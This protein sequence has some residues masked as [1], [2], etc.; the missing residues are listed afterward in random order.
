[1]LFLAGAYPRLTAVM[2]TR[3]LW[4]KFS[5]LL[6]LT[7]PR[8]RKRWASDE[9]LTTVGA[10]WR[11]PAAPSCLTAGSETRRGWV[12][13]NFTEPKRRSSPP[14]WPESLFLSPPKDRRRRSCKS[15]LA[16]IFC[17]CCCCCSCCCCRGCCFC[18]CCSCCCNRCS[19]CCCC[20]SWWCRCPLEA[21]R[22]LLMRSVCGSGR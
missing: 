2:E 21:L 4:R 19:C 8:I 3:R 7:R 16:W 9:A 14:T 18:C 13:G 15:F 6:L 5:E 20:G 1:M 22:P 11:L 12:F 17:C 10:R